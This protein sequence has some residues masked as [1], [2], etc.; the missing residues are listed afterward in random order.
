MFLLGIN[1]LITER[2]VI[3]LQYELL[4]NNVSF[5]VSKCTS[6]YKTISALGMAEVEFYKEATQNGVLL[7]IERN[8][9]PGTSVSIFDSNT[10]SLVFSTAMDQ[11]MFGIDD[12][13]IKNITSLKNGQTEFYL[14]VEQN[15][16]IKA[17]ASFATYPEWNWLIVSYSSTDKLFGYTH[18][19]MKITIIL[20]GI[21]LVLIL[22][23]IYTL[24][25][26]VS[27]SIESLQKGALRLAKNDLDVK[28]E[29][30]DKGKGS[31]EFSCL[32]D[33]FN[34]MAAEIKKTQLQL[35]ESISDERKTHQELKQSKQR[36]TLALFG[37]DLGLWDYDIVKGS[38][39]Y[40]ERWC[41]IIG[42]NLGEV[43]PSVG[44]WRSLLHPDDIA[45]AHNALEA[46][47]QGSG[48]HYESEFRMRHKQGHWVWILARGKVVERDENH[49]PLR[50]TGTH[51]DISERKNAEANLH[52]AASVFDHAREGIAI[53]SIDGRII[54]VNNAFSR[55]TGY[56]R[57]DA[58]GQNQ[59]MLRSDRDNFEYVADMVYS[60]NEH[61]YWYGE[62][63]NRH[64]NGKTYA[65]AEAVNAVPGPSGETQ[66][67]VSLFSDVTVI[68]EHQQQL[69]RLA[70]FDDLTGLA[71]RTQ[72]SSFL[73]IAMTHA[74]RDGSELAIAYIDLDGFKTINDC[75]GHEIGDKFLI[76]LAVHMEQSIPKSSMLA[77]IGGDEFVAVLVDLDDAKNC[78]PSLNSLKSAA[79]KKVTFIEHEL[80]V[81]ASIG[82]AYY[83]SDD[84]IDAEQL[85]RRA[86]QAM[87][88]AKV[89]GKNRY[90]LFD[91]EQDSSLR[92]R[93]ESQE[94][95]SLALEHG[96]F[97]L[98]Y[99]PK[100][101][102]RTGHVIGAEALIRWQH[103]EKGLL[104][105]A[106][107]LPLIETHSQAIVVGEWVIDT[108]LKQMKQWLTEGLDIK[109]SVNIG[110]LQLQQKN[111]VE[112]LSGA[113]AAH[114]K[115]QSSHL[116]L[117]ILETTKL[118]DFPHV[119]E[120]LNACKQIGV[121]FALDDFGTGYSSLTYLKE[122]KVGLLKV[123]QSFVRDML[124][125]PDDLAIIRGI[126][127]LA[128]AFKRQVIAEGVETVEHG[129][130]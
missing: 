58:L 30:K 5:I 128:S 66:H 99:Q 94:R 76:S 124:D 115:I 114:P 10:N 9:S 28:I 33:S 56:S 23:I 22:S 129:I 17:L 62:I 48:D 45:P 37:A 60:L 2:K 3:E 6:E 34:T 44:F 32:A 112:R 68:K 74:R 43:E 108:A 82:V 109:I 27:R 52:L 19:A 50:M 57:V 1:F 130:E 110:A 86:D 41:A 107:F 13:S 31:D 116:E 91:T 102:M 120:V 61:G 25:G 123:D 113:L 78:I 69:E 92:H 80:Q 103:P 98:H 29:I 14:Q 42:R 40:D 90:H 15:E 85:L 20:A 47:L 18:D 7:D 125:D 101:N 8:R 36:Q 89:A 106:D 70:H 117:E 105:P 26:N 35:T 73:Q 63:W 21:F 122:L 81:S 67:Y 55:I 11:G 49:A 87:Y 111:F 16:N 104:L 24:S 127:S 118:E 95:I 75:Y 83:G 121:E 93:H 38:V 126:I 46:H 79:T 59:Q 53:T 4:S 119:S 88:Q 51:M 64:K 100:V 96:E 65:V 54:D 84:E 39:I 97:V 12:T 77:R 72:L 71:N